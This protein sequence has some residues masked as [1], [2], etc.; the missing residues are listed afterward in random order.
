MKKKI[1]SVCAI[2]CAF[3]MCLPLA[4]CSDKRDDGA[5]VSFVGIDINPSI[6][7]TLDAKN[8][9]ISVSGA[10]EDG[11]VLLYG[12]SGII[13]ES[14]EKAVEKITKL[15]VSLGYLDEDNSVVLTNVTSAKKG[16]ADDILKKIN[17]KITATAGESWS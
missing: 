13:G 12:E 11:Q 3:A 17:A 10:N 7:L 16:K 1:L 6:E 2:V 14:A 15:A 9:V 8:K 4:A 5:A